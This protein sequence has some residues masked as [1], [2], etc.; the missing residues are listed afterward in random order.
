MAL[1]NTPVW[2]QSTRLDVASVTTANTATDGTGTITTLLTAGADGTRVDGLYAGAG[3]TVT[4]TAVR[5]FVDPDGASGWTYVPDLEGLIPAHTLAATTLNGGQVTIINRGDQ[6]A[7]F[8][9]PAGAILGFTIAVTISSEA[10][11]V[12]AW[13]HD[14]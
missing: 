5:F 9:L 13:G 1:T 14:F 12:T 2:P 3:A 8:D 4:A 11:Y 7:F 10:V 6:T